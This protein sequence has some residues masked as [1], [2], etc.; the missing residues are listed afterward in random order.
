M[1]E[2]HLS[3]YWG[4]SLSLCSFPA[5]KWGVM[6]IQAEERE[7]GSLEPWSVHQS[8]QEVFL[9]LSCKHRSF[10]SS[11]K[12]RKTN[13]EVTTGHTSLAGAWTSQI[14]DQLAHQESWMMSR[15]K[16][17]PP[18]FSLKFYSWR[19]LNENAQRLLRK[20]RDVQHFIVYPDTVRA[21]LYRAPTRWE[22]QASHILSW[23]PYNS[24]TSIIF[25]H[26]HC[27]HKVTKA[28]QG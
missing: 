16:N 7:A 8:L 19:K 13:V 1:C 23:C 27:T 14:P 21:S 4:R 28:E 20:G 22:H 26:L 18:A 25:H 10:Y 5:C 17:H 12:V 24:L 6:T 2:K 11:I 3:V 9:E 15:E